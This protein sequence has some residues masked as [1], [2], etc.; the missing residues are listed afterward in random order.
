MN[1]NRSHTLTGQQDDVHYYGASSIRRFQCSILNLLNGCTECHRPKNHT[2]VSNETM[3]L[4]PFSIY[5]NPFPKQ[6][7]KVA[8]T[9]IFGKHGLQVK[10]FPSSD[11]PLL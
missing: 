8:G 10:L 1:R 2:I 6:R 5:L 11:N 7:H 4:C 9:E 3:L